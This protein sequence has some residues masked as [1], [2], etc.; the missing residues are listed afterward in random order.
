MFGQGL[1]VTAVQAASVFATIANDGVRVEPTLIAGQSDPNGNYRAEPAGA[2]SRVV[3]AATAT[4]LRNMMQAVVSEAG[5]AAAAEIP[6]YLVAGKTGRRT[7]RRR[8]RPVQR[9]HRVLHRAGPGRRPRTRRGGHP[10]GPEDELLRRFGGGAGL[11][12]RHD[13]RPGP[14]RHRASAE[15]PADLPLTWGGDTGASR[16][17]APARSP[18]RPLSDLCRAGRPPRDG[19]GDTRPC[20]A[21]RDRRAGSLPPCR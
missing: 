14:A 2:S 13:V 21:D 18:T 10:A 15:P 3:S 9:L 8:P 7:V 16:T 5:T 6:G 1:S 19:V 4:T 11:Q 17:S 12:G 20:G